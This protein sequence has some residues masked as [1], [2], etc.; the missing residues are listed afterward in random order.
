MIVNFQPLTAGK[1]RRFIDNGSLG[2]TKGAV[3]NEPEAVL[4]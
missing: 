1:F 2:N 3:I 4:I